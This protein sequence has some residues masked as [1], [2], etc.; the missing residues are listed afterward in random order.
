[1]KSLKYGYLTIMTKICNQYLI[2]VSAFVVIWLLVIIMKSDEKSMLLKLVVSSFMR[3]LDVQKENF[4]FECDNERMGLMFN[5]NFSHYLQHFKLLIDH[6]PDSYATLAEFPVFVTAFSD[7]H[8][9]EGERLITHMATY[10]PTK[11]LVVYDIGLS[12]AKREQIRQRNPHVLLKQFNFSAYPS[13]VGVL[14]EY[15]WKPLVIAEELLLHPAVVWMDSSVYWEHGNISELLIRIKNQSLFPWTI[16]EFTDITVEVQKY[17]TKYR[18][19]NTPLSVFQTS[20]YSKHVTQCIRY[21]YD[22]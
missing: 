10:F 14:T 9:Y 17:H 15:R 1:M 5:A 20:D 12:E 21:D 22:A 16:M 13:Y 18:N 6:K 8:I 3:S 2:A 11:K 7:N 19:R 4:V